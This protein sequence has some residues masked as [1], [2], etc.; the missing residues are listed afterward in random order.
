MAHWDEAQRAVDGLD[1][2]VLWM[3]MTPNATST[4]AAR[5]TSTSTSP[6]VSASRVSSAVLMAWASVLVCSTMTS[7]GLLRP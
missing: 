6:P 3:L 1:Q 5:I 4:P 2:G 7:S